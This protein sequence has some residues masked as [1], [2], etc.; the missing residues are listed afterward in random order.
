MG[1]P[2]ERAQFAL[3]MYDKD[4]NV[5]RGSWRTVAGGFGHWSDHWGGPV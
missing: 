4:E 3:K 1:T 5:D 2:E